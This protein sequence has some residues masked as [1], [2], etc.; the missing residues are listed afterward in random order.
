MKGWECAGEA[1]PIYLCC[2]LFLKLLTAAGDRM[3]VLDELTWWSCAVTRGIEQDTLVAKLCTT[4]D[5]SKL[6]QT[7]T[8]SYLANHG[9]TLLELQHEG[10]EALCNMMSLQ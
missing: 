8:E 5:T 2:L 6:S 3:L 10:A 7:I 1:Y 4:W 9:L